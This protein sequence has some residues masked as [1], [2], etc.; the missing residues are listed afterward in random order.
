MPPKPSKMAAKKKAAAPVT[1]GS[2]AT[3]APANVPKGETGLK[4]GVAPKK[5]T[6][7]R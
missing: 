2:S 4:K 1:K 6:G 7:A 5:K 3:K